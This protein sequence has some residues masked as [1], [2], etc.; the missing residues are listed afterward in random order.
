MLD[1][2]CASKPSSEQVS[3]TAASGTVSEITRNAADLLPRLLADAVAADIVTDQTSAHDPLSY[4]PNDLT[5]E[6]ADRHP[7]IVALETAEELRES[8][9]VEL[10]GRVEHRTRDLCGF[11]VEPVGMKPVHDA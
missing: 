7:A 4:M 11:G 9:V 2:A 5:P 3:C 6:A 10:L 1:G 8:A